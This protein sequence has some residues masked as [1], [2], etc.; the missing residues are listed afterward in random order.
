MTHGEGT[1]L[2]LKAASF[3]LQ[4]KH[5]STGFEAGFNEMTHR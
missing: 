1:N 4:L 3:Q 2:G 5:I